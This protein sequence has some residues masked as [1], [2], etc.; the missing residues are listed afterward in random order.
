MTDE[1]ITRDDIAVLTEEY[2]QRLQLLKETWVE[3]SRHMDDARQKGIE[4]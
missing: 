1:E 2:N 3:L 4:V